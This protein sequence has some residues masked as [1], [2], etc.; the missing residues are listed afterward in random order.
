MIFAHFDK[1]YR[2]NIKYF[3]RKYRAHYTTFQRTS[4]E[5]EDVAAETCQRA[6]PEVGDL[7][8]CPGRMSPLCLR[9]L[10]HL[11]VESFLCYK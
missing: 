3:A 11:P 2:P 6:S 1:N 4:A 9:D 7:M 5:M 10:L 8:L